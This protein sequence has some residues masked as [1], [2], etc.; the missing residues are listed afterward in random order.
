MTQKQRKSTLSTFGIVSIVILFIVGTFYVIIVSS[1]SQNEKRNEQ[2]EQSKQTKP[3]T[4]IVTDPE[5][6]QPVNRQALVSQSKAIVIGEPISNICVLSKDSSII[7]IVY[8]FKINEIVKG[9]LKIEDTIKISLPGGVV[10]KPDG[11]MLVVN[12]PGFKKI[13]NNSTYL[14]FLKEKSQELTTVRGPQ[15]IFEF[16]NNSSVI[17]YSNYADKNNHNKEQTID[18]VQLLQEIRGLK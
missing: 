8:T 14:L 9:N 7:K 13:K 5:W 18:A 3:D 6:S 2:I 15:G 10:P 1:Q 12:T 17:P 4:R 16:V 11:S